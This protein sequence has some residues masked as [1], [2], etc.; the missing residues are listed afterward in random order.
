[1]TQFTVNEISPAYWRVTFENGQVNLVDPDEIEEL[2]A[3]VG[4]IERSPELAVVFFD[5]ANP[6]YFMAHYDFTADAARVAAMTPGPTGLHPYVDNF[7]R[8]SKVP[9]VTI[10]AVRGRARGAGSEFVLA[11]DI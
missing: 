7:V 8:L 5:S 2:A 9:V 11:T 6:D 4:R 1:M 3:L 10:S